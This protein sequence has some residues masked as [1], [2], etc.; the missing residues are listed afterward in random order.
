MKMQLILYNSCS[1]HAH[2]LEMT[3]ESLARCVKETL[4]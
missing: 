1:P 2:D 4:Q 3:V